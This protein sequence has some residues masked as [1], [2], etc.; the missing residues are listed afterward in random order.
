[1]LHELNQLRAYFGMV[2]HSS[3]LNKYSRF[4]KLH[5]D[6]LKSLD[7]CYNL[8]YQEDNVID[9][10]IAT[11]LREDIYKFLTERAE[12]I[13]NAWYDEGLFKMYFGTGETFR[14]L[15]DK[16]NIPYSSIFHNIKA[17]QEIIKTKFK[18]RYDN[19]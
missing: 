1:M 8:A 19:L 15:S 6:R 10:D 17:T 13:E 2:I 11:E 3:I 16:T 14:S 18:S 4:N 9:S 7:E 12:N 5:G